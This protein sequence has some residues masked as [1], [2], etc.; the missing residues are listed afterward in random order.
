MRPIP[1][2][3]HSLHGLAQLTEMLAMASRRDMP[4]YAQYTHSRYPG[5]V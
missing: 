5:Y 3:V 1:H 2:T 4:Y